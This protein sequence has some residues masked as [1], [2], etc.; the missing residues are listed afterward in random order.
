[1][2][3]PSTW[4]VATQLYSFWNHVSRWTPTTE[5][6][7]FSACFLY[8]SRYACLLSPLDC[9][10][11]FFY[12]HTLVREW[13]IIVPQ[14]VT[15]DWRHGFGLY[16]RMPLLNPFRYPTHTFYLWHYFIWGFPGGSISKE[17]ACNAEDPGSIPGSGRPSW[18]RKWMVTHSSILDWE[19]NPMD[20][21]AWQAKVHGVTK[22]QTQLSD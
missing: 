17:S 14:Q 18:R 15:C 2:S 10:S 12:S 1:M 3:P 11:H 7:C 21:G 13:G 9:S 6:L 5:V 16:K 8:N 4:E 19:I 20:R 22:G